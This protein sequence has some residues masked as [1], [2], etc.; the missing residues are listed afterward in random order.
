LHVQDIQPSPDPEF[1]ECPRCAQPVLKDNLSRQWNE[2]GQICLCE[3]CDSFK[4]GCNVLDEPVPALISDLQRL[5]ATTQRVLDTVRQITR[6]PTEIPA[7]VFT[8]RLENLIDELVSA[9]CH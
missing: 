6:D 2:W 9:W 7:R 4:A 1:V 3:S 5:P 8:S